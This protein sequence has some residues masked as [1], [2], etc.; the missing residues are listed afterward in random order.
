[1][2]GSICLSGKKGWNEDVIFISNN[3]LTYKDNEYNYTLLAL[4]DGVTGKGGGAT[5]AVKAIT[6][7][8]ASFNAIVMR[9]QKE[10]Y[11]RK[12]NS[13]AKFIE[14]RVRESFRIA[15]SEIKEYN[16]IGHSNITTTLVTALIVEDKNVKKGDDNL[17]VIIGN[18]GDSRAYVI[19][20]TLENKIKQITIDHSVAQEVANKKKIELTEAKK[21]VGHNELSRALGNVE[22]SENF[23][24]DL[25]FPFLFRNEFLLLCSDG[26]SDYLSDEDIASIVLK[27][28]DPQNAC[29]KL[30]HSAL[31]K[32]SKDNI[33]ILIF[34]NDNP[35]NK[36]REDFLEYTISINN[37]NKNK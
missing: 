1:M 4:A 10:Q 26:L 3:S 19:S 14:K 5:A 6:S 18:V 33:S 37:S 31:D 2:L 13:N 34:L 20:E 7:F 17:K 32:N 22:S 30:Y 29:E 36:T 16:K 24:V 12:F 35:T 21:K 23:S 11:L 28:K 15:D 8:T 9:M 27:A 25:F